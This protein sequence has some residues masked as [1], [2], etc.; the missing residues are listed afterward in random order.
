MLKTPWSSVPFNT[1]CPPPP[2]GRSELSMARTGP[3]ENNNP[4]A[5]SFGRGLPNKLARGPKW[6]SY[7]T[8]KKYDFALCL[9]FTF[10]V[11]INIIASLI[12]NSILKRRPRYN[13]IIHSYAAPYNNSARRGRA[14]VARP[15]FLPKQAR[16]PARTPISISL[17]RPIT[18]R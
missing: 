15:S 18:R 3:S 7:A 5:R 4:G 6:S 17:W 1:P 13:N 2:H 8:A 11:W 9:L 14:E 12:L 16:A 10:F